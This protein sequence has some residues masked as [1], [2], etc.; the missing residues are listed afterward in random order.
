MKKDKYEELLEMHNK[1]VEEISSI[2]DFEIEK[3]RKEIENQKQELQSIYNS[4]AWK[5]ITK[6]REIKT[7][8]KRNN[9][10]IFN[11]IIEKINDYKTKE[12]TNCNIEYN[13]NNPLITYVIPGC[14]ISGGVGVVCQHVNR[15]KKRG[16]NVLLITEGKD[17]N[18]DWFPNQN[19]KIVTLDNAPKNIDIL[20]AT[21]W[22]TAYASKTLN[23]CKRMYFVQSDESRFYAKDSIEQK[24][25][26]DTYSMDFIFITEA[27]WI[28]KW[29]K[30]K[31]NKESHY[32]PNGIDTEYI[33]PTIDRYSNQNRRKRVLLEGPIDI[34]YKGME[35]AFNAIKD[36]D[37]EV[38][39]VSTL[40]KPKKEWKCDK[41]FENVPFTNMNYLYSNCDVLLKMSRIEGFF[42]P[43]MEMMACK[44]ACVVGKVSG[45]DEY[46]VDEENALV[47]EQGDI[48]AACY[49]VKKLL[50]DDKLRDKLSSNG[51]KT[52][53]KWQ[54]DRSID[55]L[56]E[57][58]NSLI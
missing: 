38:W 19:V 26:L 13:N 55:L 56:E 57:I 51:Y 5:L 21:S 14:T 18:I 1:D 52:S 2:Y 33:Y 17:T 30:E 24:L 3:Y 6:Y 12:I 41:F 9:D 7:S 8:F 48:N 25:V 45:Y 54:W 28:Q 36:L 47:V 31:F 42:G 22:T 4:K 23:A 37:C 53:K 27:K 35:D 39:C 34:P 44:G 40:G 16:Y 11:N 50:E 32:V 10:V 29:L 58:I 46:I 20:I 15:L 43:P 49:A